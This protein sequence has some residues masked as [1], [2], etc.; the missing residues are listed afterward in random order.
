MI[1]H[2]FDLSWR[3]LKRTPLVSLLMI[4]AI[5]IGI[6]VTMTSLSVYHMMSLDPI[7]SKSSKLFAVQ[8]QTMDESEDWW[9]SD[10]MPYQLTFKDAEYLSTA[11][12]AVRQTAL[13]KS[14]FAVHLNK[15]DDKP[16]LQT[17]RAANADF[18]TMVNAPFAYGS[19]WSKTDEQDLKQVVVIGSEVNQKLFGGGNNL[20][21]TIYLDDKTFQVV[22]I[23]KPWILSSSFYDLN[24]GH[25]RDPEQ[26]YLPFTLVRANE[27]RSW[28]NNNGWK[29]ED[30]KT[31][32][33]KHNSEITWIQFW[34]ELANEKAQQDYINFLNNYV[35]E[36]KA[37]GR[38]NRESPKVSIKNVTQ[39][40][41]YN[42]VV[43][44][45]NKILVALSFM[46]LAVCLANILGLL[47][48]KFMRRAPEIG[49]RRA[50]GASK[51]QVFM[52]HIVE[53]SV[54]G[55]LGGLLGILI[56]Q[57]GL[58]GIR[59][60]NSNYE[61]LATMDL[62]MLLA[63]PSIAIAACIIAGIYPAWQVCRTTP[64]LYLKTQ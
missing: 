13:L 25:F 33:D 54:L 36:Q 14:G 64:A 52:Q 60:T 1:L 57:I 50:L 51:K 4:L 17:T 8:L 37:L 58:L 45:D 35:A 46:F 24:N 29:H 31:E 32:K 59:Q 47:L 56:A 3:S 15:P 20:G 42:K 55:F 43:S 23:L 34:V 53:V 44:E 11:N 2:Y 30:I 61:S 10:N 21:K 18:F 22:G 62:S 38:F 63:A 28:G 26:V 5:A 48:A 16:L 40:L 7:P 39:W 41:E 6:G 12:Q 27:I 9:T 19:A 49:V